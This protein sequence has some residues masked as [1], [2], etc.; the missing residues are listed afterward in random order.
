MSW[1]WYYQLL[2]LSAYL[3]LLGSAIAVHWQPRGALCAVDAASLLP[4]FIGIHNAW[5]NISYHVMNRK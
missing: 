5:D 3:T 1:I 4:L 2:P